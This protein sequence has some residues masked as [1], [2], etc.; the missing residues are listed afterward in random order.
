MHGNE[1]SGVK[2]TCE[3]KYGCLGEVVKVLQLISREETWVCS[4][5]SSLPVSRGAVACQ[6]Q[7]QVYKTLAVPNRWLY[8]AHRLAAGSKGTQSQSHGQTPP[9]VRDVCQESEC[10][11]RSLYT[12]G[13]SKIA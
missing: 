5:C 1:V 6:Y 7:R 9:I 8:G 3:R 11:H 12:Y 13:S 10:Y 2:L 4:S